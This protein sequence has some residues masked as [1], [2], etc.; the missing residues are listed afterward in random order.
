MQIA[1]RNVFV[2]ALCIYST[3]DYCINHMFYICLV[4]E[5]HHQ[6]GV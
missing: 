1:R 4:P 2:F 6:Q 5:A 3:P